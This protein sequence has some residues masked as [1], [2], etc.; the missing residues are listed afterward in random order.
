[1]DLSIPTYPIKT[2]SILSA[3]LLP[4][5]IF[6]NLAN[7]LKQTLSLIK[8][9]YQMKKTLPLILLG[10]LLTN[11]LTAQTIRTIYTFTNPEIIQ[12]QDGYVELNMRECLNMGEEGQPFLP[13]HGC[14]VLLPQGNKVTAINILSIKY[15]ELKQ[16]VSILPAS[17]PFPISQ[18]APD[19]YKP[20]PIPEIYQSAEAF[21]EN[22]IS[23]F[24]TQFMAGYSIA[25]FNICPIQYFP[26]LHSFR[27]IASIEVEMETITTDDEIVVPAQ[28]S[29]HTTIRLE[30][31]VD[32]PEMIANYSFARTRDYDQIDMLIISKEM[33]L[34][35]FDPYIEYKTAKGFIIETISTEYIYSNYSGAD[36]QEQ[37]RNCIRDFYQN[38]GVQYVILGGD[39][40]PNNPNDKIVPHR[41][42]YVDTGYGTLDEDIP[43]DMYYSCLDMNWDMNGNGLYGE[44]GEEDIF[45][46][47]F[48][49]RFCIDEYSELENLIDKTILYQESPVV[50]DI[51]KALMLGEALDDDT[52]G[53][54]YKDEVAD[55]SS[56]FGYTTAGVSDN[57]NVTRLYEMNGYW[58]KNDVFEEFN[59]SG[60]NLLNHL[61]HSSVTY[62]MKMNN[63]D[64]TTNNIQNDGIGRGFVIGY[65]Q[66]CY[67]GAFDNRGSS[68]NYID[69]CFSENITT[70]ETAEVA[71][72]GNSR[73]GWYQTNS[74]NG[75]SQYLDREFFDAIF[76]ESITQIGMAV[77]DSKED[78]ASF[79]NANKIIRW[80][81]YETIL[82]GDPSMDIWTAQPEEF[83][84][85]YQQAIPIGSDELVVETDAPRAR[86]GLMQN[87][88]LIGS[89]LADEN[90]FATVEFFAPIATNEA[91]TISITAHNK[92][93]YNDSISV[94]SD[95]P[96]VIFESLE[97]ND[98]NGNNNGIPEFGEQIY[99]GLGLT[100]LGNQPAED[101]IVTL[102]CPD[103][104]IALTYLA[105]EFGDFEPGETIFIEDAFDAIIADNIPDLHEIVIEVHANGQETWV[106]DFTFTVNAPEIKVASL[107]IDDFTGNNNGLLDPGET[108]IF[109]FDLINQGHATSP[110]INMQCISN[111][112]NVNI[113]GSSANTDPL[114]PDESCILGFEGL[115]NPDAGFGHLADLEVIIQSGAYEF[116]EQFIREIGIIAEDFETGDF[117]R[118]DWQFD[119]EQEWEIC[120]VNPQQGA[121]CIMSGSI[122]HSQTSEIKVEVLVRTPDAISFY[123]KVS[124]EAGYDHLKFYIDEQFKGQWSGEDDWEKVSFAVNPGLHTFRWVYEKD[125]NVSNGED[126]AW[127]DFIEFPPLI[128]SSLWAGADAEACTGNNFT[129][130]ATAA[131]V[132]DILW[133]TSGTGTFD[134]PGILQTEYIPSHEDFNSGSI[135]LALTGTGTG[136]EPLSDEMELA[137]IDV[138]D[139]PGTPMGEIEVCTNY[140]WTYQYHVNMVVDAGVYIWEL[141]PAEAGTVDGEGR[142]V[143][144]LWADSYEGD[145]QLHVKTVNACGESEFSESLE[146][147]A[148]ICSGIAENHSKDIYIS[149]N[150]NNGQFSIYLPGH[151]QVADFIIFNSFGQKIYEQK[152]GILHSEMDINLSHQ[153]SGLYYLQVKIGESRF[154]SKVMIR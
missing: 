148:H 147:S 75:G 62:N 142:N 50:R 107:T 133:E 93:P 12:T 84:L 96:Y 70:I 9:F 31:I 140:G 55:G 106:S 79:I 26:A 20:V 130:D 8:K 58:N 19:D 98:E 47:V 113:T 46:E 80:C 150:P 28:Q 115:V 139:M 125:V 14:K 149:P 32:N 27:Y 77:G 134:N 101:V 99:M 53:G 7:L 72:V 69:D 103:Q 121:Y 129:T 114:S 23:D 25:L 73:Y 89:A 30:K 92:I 3:H 108:V 18:P 94:I 102:S 116:T 41:G 59:D 128:Q 39:A 86:I 43:S 146:I 97:I 60:C 82:F 34:P 95:Q 56:N 40:D 35:T 13:Y 57:F 6:H 88:T 65:S 87:D 66:G 10:L 119:G 33:F 68:G 63:S 4:G 78:N 67:S 49:G 131:F 15:S 64:I 42:F 144:V 117:S 54:N 74:T 2:S 122:D 153:P 118:F 38:M 109:L 48:I 127:I 124:S 45:A 52:W 111:N 5:L 141:I 123:R 44:P 135:M 132:E 11:F 145:V 17:R 1:M 71:T 137:F 29:P 24:S 22:I 154:V 126:C 100:N 51:E 120:S 136:N 16:G 91:I 85:V 151:N 76:G 21:P 90:G 143:T 105:V 138:P 81:A 83:T 104:F 110:D 112:S 37:I 61:G 152:M 36:E